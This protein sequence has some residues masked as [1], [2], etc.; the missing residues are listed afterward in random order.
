MR[1]AILELERVILPAIGFDFLV[2]HPHLHALQIVHD[3]QEDRE[4]A[5]LSWSICNDV[6]RTT[7]CVQY[8]PKLVAAATVYLSACFLRR[9][10]NRHPVDG[11]GSQRHRASWWERLGYASLD[12]DGNSSRTSVFRNLALPLL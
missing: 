10:L 9:D 8:L 6:Y 11:S 5:R 3:L 2:E 4:L 12:L 1:D 7:I